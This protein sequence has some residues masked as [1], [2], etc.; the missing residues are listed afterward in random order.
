MGKKLYIIILL[1][2]FAVI[3]EGQ[4]IKYTLLSANV[5]QFHH[6]IHVYG[7]K[8]SGNDLTFKCFSFSDK[9]QLKDSIE[10]NLGKHH[11]SDYLEI[12][13]DTLHDVLN[14]Y[15]Q[16][17]N[18]KNIVSLLRLNDSLRKIGTAENYDANH[19]N[20]LSVFDDEKYTFKQDM[21]I[22][23]TSSDTSGKQFYLSK[24]HVKAMDK[25]FEYEYKWQFAFER[26]HIH[27][28]SIIYADT[29]QVIVYAHVFD[30]LKKG[31][32]ILRINANTGEVIRGTKLNAKGDPRYFL[33]SGVIFNKKT[34]SIEVIGS[35]Y[36]GNML[37]FKNKTSNFTNQSKNHKLFLVLIDSLGD[38]AVRV[39][40]AFPMPI[41]TKA[42]SVLQSFH[43]KIREF[44]KQADGS[45]VIWTDIYE[46]SLPNVFAYYSS[47]QFTLV[48]NDVDYEIVRSI[49]TIG[50]K[51]IPN[52]MSF[53][54]GDTYGKFILNDIG[55][56]DK[57]KYKKPMNDVVIKTGLINNTTFYILKKTDILSSKKTYNYVS[58]GKK[59]LENKI[60]LKAEQGQQSNLFFNGVTSYISFITNIGNSD[61]ELKLNTL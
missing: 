57:F 37:D 32:W 33:M 2:S 14:F 54:K 18:Q 24:Y 17:A 59:G 22:I 12:T 41:Q 5:L 8:Q 25:A 20:A 60:I 44:N 27:R 1:L 3:S 23:R 28:A 26:K 43:L 15:F 29:S 16:L 30:G 7:Y 4:S 52:F 40:K 19:I 48:P 56:Y 50:S 55:E 38:A 46:Q 9:L 61:F 36:D 6:L 51:A 49:F 11:P 31:Q 34:K 42:G 10:L 21:Y 45:Y 13:V 58:M 47:W 39:E 35:I 53:G